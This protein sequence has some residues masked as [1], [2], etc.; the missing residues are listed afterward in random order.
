MLTPLIAEKYGSF[1]NLARQHQVI[2]YYVGYFSQNIVAAMA[3]AVK[4]QLEVS[5]VAGPTRRKLFSSFVEM[6]QN[7]IH[8]SAVS[9]TPQKQDDGELRHGSVCIRRECDGSFLLLCANP[10]EQAVA[11]DLRGKLEALREMTL[12]E[13]KQAYRQTLREETPL[14]SK[15]AGIGLLTVARDAREP[16]EFDFDVTDSAGQTPVFY[17]KAAI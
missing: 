12:D 7:I 9:L 5:G 6:A 8:Y 2:F 1:F 15:G 4:L 10:V 11:D 17:L 16:L 3:E 13:I 14:G